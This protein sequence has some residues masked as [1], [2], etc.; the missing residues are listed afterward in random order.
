MAGTSTTPTRDVGGISDA[1]IVTPAELLAFE[2]R[3]PSWHANKETLIRNELGLS[4]AR[5]V[6]LLERAASSREGLQAD[7]FT[8]HRVA[9][10]TPRRRRI[11]I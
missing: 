4:P 10:F 3:Y 5:Y 7:P 8:A 9:S 11:A 1:R 2:A 6:I